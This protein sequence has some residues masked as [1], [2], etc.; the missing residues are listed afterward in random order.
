MLVECG[1]RRKGSEGHY[2]CWE[3]VQ[4]CDG[5]N[6]RI[7]GLRIQILFFVC[8]CVVLLGIKPRSHLL[9]GWILPII[10]IF[11]K[12]I[13]SIQFAFFHTQIYNYTHA[14]TVV[15]VM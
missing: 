7:T 2:F 15:S 8:V 1:A 9:K 3:A 10:C 11:G 6:F 5:V 14:H 13:N 4:P 12:K